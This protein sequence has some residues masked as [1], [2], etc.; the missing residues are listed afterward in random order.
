[1][2]CAYKFIYAIIGYDTEGMV[3]VY[4]QSDGRKGSSLL[5]NKRGYILFDGAIGTYMAQ[6]YNLNIKRCEIENIKNPANVEAIHREYIAAGADAIKT[7]TFAAN[8]SALNADMDYVIQVINAGCTC[9]KAA[10]GETHT[11][12]FASIG[13]SDS[14]DAIDEYRTIIDS[15]LKNG[16]T[17]FL[18]ETFDDT[19][20]L[21][22]SARYLKEKA[23]DAYAIC[24]CSVAPDRYTS[25]GLSAQYIIDS[26]YGVEEID[27]Y[28]FNCTCGPLHMETI[29]NDTDFYD[30]PFS[31]MPNAGYPTVI[32]GRTVFE[33]TPEYFASQL[34]KIRRAGATYL[35]GCCGTTPA[36][37][38][39]SRRALDADKQAPLAPHGKSGGKTEKQERKHRKGFI[40]VELDSP[41]DA[42]LDPFIMHAKQ[43]SAAGADVITIADCP[44][45]R[46]R[47]D[48]SMLA[49][50]LKQKFGI[51]ALPHLTCRDRN[52]NASKALLLGLNMHDITNV[53]VVT[54]D[55]IPT[56][57]RGQIKSVYDFNSV[58]YAAFIN[59]LNGSTFIKKPFEIMGALNI[60]ADN[61]D[62][63]LNKALKK[64]EAGM[65]CFLT[66]P[67]F[68]ERGAE[69]LRLARGKL[70]SDILAGIMPIV[71]YRNAMF[72]NNE[73]SGI[74]VP[75][76]L[77]D[78]YKD[79]SPERAAA[80]AVETACGIAY[81]VR[82][83]VN[84]YYII[85]TLKRADIVCKIIKEIKKWL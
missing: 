40:A 49:G 9:A 6:K 12:I 76:A 78:K 28:G 15:F 75:Q 83:I 27:A 31:I 32:N 60:N 61:F 80:L 19:E 4:I 77:M 69:N 71:S 73:I 39:A 17:N 20:E 10:A 46:A 51:E 54:G 11:Q 34:V 23:P 35:G 44:I 21:I 74:R 2:S 84:G 58:K 59:D 7:N 63:E 56:Q 5:E 24:E 85:T 72:V 45:G 29:V 81:E 16:I 65:S 64:E 55:P 82:D 8:T 48:S 70:D 47:A 3:S 37:I 38:A 36:H 79:A 1:V 42:E 41:L 68:D 57:Q 50:M 53:L 18:F 26:L 33:S 14:P 43:I 25:G 52:L 22:V 13:P 66:Q 62:A 67:V 30:K